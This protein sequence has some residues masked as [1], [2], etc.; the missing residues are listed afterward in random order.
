MRLFGGCAPPPPFSDVH[1]P[2][3]DMRGSEDKQ[4]INLPLQREVAQIYI[5]QLELMRLHS[6]ILRQSLGL[7]V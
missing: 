2:C 6:F 5:F 1:Q 4:S 3:G 7:V